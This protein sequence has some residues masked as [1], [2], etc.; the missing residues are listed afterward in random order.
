M[1]NQPFE[2]DSDSGDEGYNSEDEQDGVVHR[3]LPWYQFNVHSTSMRIWDSFW[4]L[5]LLYT[6]IWTPLA[7]AFQDNFHGNEDSGVNWVA[8]DVFINVLWFIAFLINLNRV[9]FML[10]IVTFE[11]TWRAYNSSLF[12]L[13]DAAILIA[14]VVL[15]II[16]EPIYAKYF[17]LLR[18]LHYNKA[19][20]PVNLAI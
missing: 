9:D 19:L 2:T 13:P 11:E 18:I 7:I 4:S 20:F 6:I 12:M 14:S 5:V 1:L 17:E 3:G 15:I 10:Q 8:L 16:D